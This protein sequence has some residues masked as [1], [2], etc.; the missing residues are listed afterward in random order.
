MKKFVSTLI[1]SLFLV[2]CTA[3]VPLTEEQQAA[4][5]GLTV[6]RYREEKE[7]AARMGM[8]W[9]EHVKMIQDDSAMDHD[10]GMHMDHDM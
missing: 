4:K 2:G 10:D 6:E 1:L 7:A 3:Q 8:K 9:E 5:Y